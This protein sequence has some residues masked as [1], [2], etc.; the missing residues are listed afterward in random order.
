YIL[1]EKYSDADC[2]PRAIAWPITKIF[3]YLMMS[4]LAHH[5]KNDYFSIKGLDSE[6]VFERRE[7]VQLVFEGFFKG[8]MIANDCFDYSNPNKK[9]T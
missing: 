4:F 7:R 3:S 1:A 2:M 6:Q 9:S 8:E 5:N